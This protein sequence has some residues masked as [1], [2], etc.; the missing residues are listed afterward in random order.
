MAMIELTLGQQAIVDDEDYP[1]LSQWKWHALK[2]PRTYY[3]ARDVKIDGK[4]VTI[5]M[6]RLI[7]QTPVGLL[8]DHINGNGLDNRRVNLRSVTHHDNMVNCARHKAG[9]SRF[10]GVSWHGPNRRWVAQITHNYKNIYIGAFLTEEEAAAAYEAR[11][12]ELRPGKIM[13]A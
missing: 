13:R 1:I 2:Q 7:N 8:T 4:R 10:R 5:W 9:S 6:H 12:L 3:A 11:R